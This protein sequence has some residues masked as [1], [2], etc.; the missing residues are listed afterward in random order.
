MAVGHVVTAHTYPVNGTQHIK[1]KRL[2]HV[3]LHC[4]ASPPLHPSSL[5]P[6]PPTFPKTRTLSLPANGGRSWLE[7]G[8]VCAPCNPSRHDQKRGRFGDEEERHEGVTL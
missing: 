1:L 8:G 4:G 5:T 6:N 3:T 2:L 7:S